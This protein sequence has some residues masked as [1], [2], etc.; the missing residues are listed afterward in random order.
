MIDRRCLTCDYYDPD[1]ECTISSPDEWYA[2]L[3]VEDKEVKRVIMEVDE[4]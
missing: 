1:Y 3:L 4:E 2:C